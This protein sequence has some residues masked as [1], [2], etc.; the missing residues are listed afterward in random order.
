MSLKPLKVQFN[1]GELS[2]WL[3]GRTDINKYNKSA[4]LCRNFIPLTEG[5]L[6]RRGGSRF[7]AM[8]PIEDSVIFKINPMPMEALVIINGVEQNS[9]E[10]ARGDYVTYEVKA[11]GYADKSG[12]VYVVEDKV[13]DVGLVS[14]SDMCSI[15]IVA[16]PNDA[17][18]KIEGYERDFAEFNKNSEVFYMVFKDGYVM[19]S[20]NVIL[21][22][23]KIIE[24][25]LEVDSESV[26]GDYGDWGNP[27]AYIATSYVGDIEK[28]NKCILIRFEKGYLPIV[29]DVNM[30]APIAIEE[31]MFIRSMVDGYSAVAYI[32]GEYILCNIRT[33]GNA[34]YYEDMLGKLV[35]G[36]SSMEQKIIGWGEDEDGNY[37]TYYKSYD[38]SVNGNVINIYRNGKVIFQ[39]NKR[40]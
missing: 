30:E 17:T 38:G 33:N 18:I 5:S 26:E 39:L 27:V 21:D 35:F 1:G 22:E 6:K 32:E 2:P 3:E 11:D 29:F 31:T 4:K 25:N 10:V 19:Q 12:K 7:V 37:A 13:I 28:Q 8:T 20:G 34:V 36:I 15:K 9:I 40:S 23:N 16:T 24:I 14:L